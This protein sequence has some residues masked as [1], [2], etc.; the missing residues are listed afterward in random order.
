[1]CTVLYGDVGRIVGLEV[2]ISSPAAFGQ[3]LL[4]NKQTN[5]TL[6]QLLPMFP[7]IGV[8]HA[9][10]ATPELL[11]Q[12]A[13]SLRNGCRSRVVSSGDCEETFA[14]EIAWAKMVLNT[15]LVAFFKISTNESS[16]PSCVTCISCSTRCVR[17]NGFG[18]RFCEDCV[19]AP[20][21]EKKSR[22]ESGPG[23]LILICAMCVDDDSSFHAIGDS[24]YCAK[25]LSTRRVL[26]GLRYVMKQ[27]NHYS[28]SVYGATL[29]DPK[30]VLLGVNGNGN[31]EG[32]LTAAKPLLLDQ[33]R[34]CV[35]M[36]RYQGLVACIFYSLVIEKR[37]Q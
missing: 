5:K 15:A 7:A 34:Y 10:E 3:L 20:T 18:Q 1:M 17:V 6:S 24:T 16:E 11:R 23:T 8:L 4:C 27:A 26:L 14:D 35:S 28:G 36:Y 21:C 2:M 29:I 9:L 25:C 33:N 13:T 22:I 37:C 12:V 19:S 31:E 30:S 32:V